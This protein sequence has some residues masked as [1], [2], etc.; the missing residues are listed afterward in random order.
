MGAKTKCQKSTTSSSSSMGMNSIVTTGVDP[1]V[2][3]SRSGNTEWL[4]SKFKM[5]FGVVCKFCRWKGHSKDQYYKSKKKFCNGGS[6]VVS[7]QSIARR[8]SILD[9]SGFE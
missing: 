1:W 5:S 4:N 8:S 9:T 2:M 6:N 3:C 7:D